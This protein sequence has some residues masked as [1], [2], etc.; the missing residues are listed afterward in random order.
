MKN[1]L[2]LILLF[3]SLHF[4]QVV[5]L[6][7]KI[8]QMIMTGFSNEGDSYERVLTDIEDYNLGGVIFFRSNIDDGNQVQLLI[9]TLQSSAATPLFTAVDQEGGLVARF[10]SSNGYQ[11]TP[12]AYKLGTEINSEDTT[13]YYAAMMAGWL[14]DA[15]FNV[16]FAPVVDVNVNP[17]SPAIGHYGRSFSDDPVVV[18]N[19]SSWF[20]DEFHQKNISTALKHFP[21]H[22]SAEDD[23]HLG[24][25]DITSTWSAVELNP[26]ELLIDDGYK[27]LVMSGHL[28]NENIDTLYPASLSTFA[29]DSLLRNELGFEGI[30][31]SDEM[32]MQAISANF[33]FE[34]AVVQ[35]VIA[36]TDI[37]L[38]STNFYE[39]QPLVP[40]IIDL[41]ETKVNENVIPVSR[42]EEAYDRITA[43]KQE[44][45]IITSTDD[46]FASILPENYEIGNYPNPFNP[47]TTIKV[48]LVKSG[49]ITLSVYNITG[50]KIAE[51]A[52]G[53][54]NQG[55]FSFKFSGA[56]FASGVYLAVLETNAGVFTHKLM[57]MK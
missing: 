7:E 21:G 40:Y 1:F 10:T 37:L 20:I 47:S 23:S 57:L 52:D 13:R 50:E 42:I 26:Y 12:S 45:Q 18:Y 33:G 3:T 24:F 34:E 44:R 38:Y 51:L 25:T 14:Y 19:H 9:E 53:Y 32:F 48:N 31:V 17:E 2:I 29:L 55:S 15:G 5:T 6:R 27:D 41:I 16:N 36:G 49:N 8:G 28:F 54:F 22:G 4:S 11:K 39:E 56:G 30:I 35:A 46:S 43:L